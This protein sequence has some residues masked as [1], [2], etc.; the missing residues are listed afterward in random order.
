[1]GEVET[2]KRK[3]K[4]MLV[5]LPLQGHLTPMLQL[6]S[7]LHSQGFSVIVAHTEFNSPNPRNHPDFAFVSFQ[8]GAPFPSG[9]FLELITAINTDC[10]EPLEKTIQQ[11][12]GQLSCVIYDSLM[13]FV[14]AVACRLELPSIFFRPT[15][16]VYMQTYHAVL[17]LHEKMLIPMQGLSVFR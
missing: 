2:Q 6:G 16:A 9:N 8:Q 17:S 11:L 3:R 4:V 14:E 15:T 7:L 5:P 10:R 1:M 13:S 12:Q